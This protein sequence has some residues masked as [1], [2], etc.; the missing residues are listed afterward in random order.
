MLEEHVLGPRPGARKERLIV[1]VV[2]LPLFDDRRRNPLAQSLARHVIRARHRKEEHK[3]KEQDSEDN[4]DPVREPAD[5]IGEH[6][7]RS[8]RKVNM[9]GITRATPRAKAA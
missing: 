7:W 3:K 6:Y 8:R 9:P 1:P 4:S 2:R 5:Q